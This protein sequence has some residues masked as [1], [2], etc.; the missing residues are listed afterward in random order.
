MR[1]TLSLDD[2]VAAELER[3]R[4]QRGVRFKEVVND[5]LRRG[6]RDMSARPRLNSLPEKSTMRLL[7]WGVYDCPASTISGRLLP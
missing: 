5:A 6:L 2:D 1:T 7:R 4:Q 3:V